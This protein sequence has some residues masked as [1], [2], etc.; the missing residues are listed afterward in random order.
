MRICFPILRLLFLRRNCESCVYHGAA[1][2]LVVRVG[3]ARIEKYEIRL[4]EKCKQI[5]NNVYRIAQK[6]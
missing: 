4:K 1:G 6:K 2:G 3:K 5:K